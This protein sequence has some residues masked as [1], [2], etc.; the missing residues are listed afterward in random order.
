MNTLCT[1]MVDQYKNNNRGCLYSI[2]QAVAGKQSR[3][4]FYFLPKHS[5][6]VCKNDC[7][8]ACCKPARVT[9]SDC[10][11][12]YAT[13]MGDSYMW[14]H[15]IHFAGIRYRTKT[16]PSFFCLLPLFS[17]LT[18]WGDGGGA[19]ESRFHCHGNLR[20]HGQ[21]PCPSFEGPAV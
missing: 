8:Q 6:E 20:F 3:Y 4:W 15:S 9:A 18:F 5:A 16:G 2:T 1:D 11:R 19:A 14:T 7:I 10:V 13:K 17:P 21:F 12:Y